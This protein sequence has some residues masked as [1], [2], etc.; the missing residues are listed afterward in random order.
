LTVIAHLSDPH[1]D[2]SEGRLHR[3]RAVVAQLM[4]LPVVDVLLLS[5][6]LT[7]HGEPEEYEQ[8]FGALPPGL[9]T[10]TVPGNHD[11]TAPYLAALQQ[12]GRTVALNTTIDVAGLRI[13]GLDSHI[14]RDDEGELGQASLEYAR[15]QVAGSDQPVVLSMH[16][17]PVP[18]GHHVMDRFGLRNGGALSELV[19]AHDNVIGIFCGHVHTALATTFAGVPLIGAPGIVSTMRL[20]S[21]TDPIAD[22]SAMPGLAVHTTTGRTISTVFHH[23]S[24]SAL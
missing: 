21:K 2:G 6:D 19:R 10:V 9:P 16:H 22:P 13:V 3:L 8:F 12:C 4:D 15:G 18:V 7:D 11:L 20:G 17:P 5:G 24:P 1:L 14:D 23:L